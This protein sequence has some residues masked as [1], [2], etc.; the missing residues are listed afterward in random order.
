MIRYLHSKSI[1]ALYWVPE[2]IP[3]NQKYLVLQSV[4]NCMQLLFQACSEAKQTLHKQLP[5]PC[6][7]PFREHLLGPV[8]IYP[9]NVK[10]RYWWGASSSEPPASLR[11]GS[12]RGRHCSPQI[13]NQ[14]RQKIGTNTG[15]ILTLTPL[16]FYEGQT[17]YPINPCLLKMTYRCN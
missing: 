7:G 3:S 5:M 8:C 11:S 1:L 14:W 15:Q 10:K 16:C 17:S 6:S 9:S 2:P 13:A 4:P 12:P